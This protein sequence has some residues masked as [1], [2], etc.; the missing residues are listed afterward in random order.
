MHPFSAAVLLLIASIVSTE[1][2]ADHISDTDHYTINYLP[3]SEYGTEEVKNIIR[4]SPE[5]AF[6]I[7][8]AEKEIYSCIL[9]VVHNGGQT[10]LENYKGP[11][12]AEFLQPLYDDR[13]ISLYGS[14]GYWL[15]DVAHGRYVLQYHESKDAKTS[16]TEYYLGN[17]RLDQTV[18]DAKKFDQ[19]N[20]P[21]TTINNVNYPYYPVYYRHGTACDLTGK[22]RTTTVMYICHENSRSVFHSITEVSTCNYEVIILTSLLCAHP[23]FAPQTSPE[24]EIRCYSMDPDSTKTR[25]AALRDLEQK[26]SNDYFE[27]YAM[28][29]GKSA[30][31]LKSAEFS[32]LV[33]AKKPRVVTPE[34]RGAG[35]ALE[36][37]RAPTPA[38]AEFEGEFLE[39][40]IDMMKKAFSGKTVMLQDL[41]RTLTDEDLVL[42]D[43]FWAGRSC[44]I[45]GQGYWKFEICYGGK[46]TQYHVENQKRTREIILGEFDPAE[47]KAWFEKNKKHAIKRDTNIIR[48]VTNLYSHGDYCNEID[49]RRTVQVK[50]RCRAPAEDTTPSIMLMSL[51]EPTTCTYT[52]VLEST[53]ICEGIQLVNDDGYISKAESAI[54]FDEQDLLKTKY[55]DGEE[56]NEIAEHVKEVFDDIY[57]A[58]RARNQREWE[59]MQEAE[60]NEAQEEEEEPE[61]EEL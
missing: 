41:T 4:N 52:L 12:P 58:Q 26:A 48:Q 43:A 36:E 32:N 51:D 39:S 37:K 60:Y 54:I 7:K 25:P 40:H 23:A 44:F 22:P 19:L 16:R 17:Y 35:M 42:M 30:A 14:N 61:N 8:T 53:L 2:N 3:Y 45:G 29:H 20:P 10:S 21:V 38:P 28:E 49:A 13:V 18:E 5:R 9:P 33:N 31:A 56:L 24:Y 15:Y 57:E 1:F 47:H 6:P 27:Q 55:L 46:I 50:F 34:K 59:D 11:T